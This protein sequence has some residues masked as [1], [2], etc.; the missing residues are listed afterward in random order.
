MPPE[1]SIVTLLVVPLAAGLAAVFLRRRPRA[2]DA[3]LTSTAALSLA[4]SLSLL[5]ATGNGEVHAL[6]AGAWPGGPGIVLVA[7]TLAAL[8]LSVC[9][10]VAL[11]TSVYGWRG[12]P[13]RYRLGRAH[14]FT[15]FMLFGVNGAFLAR[16]SDLLDA[17]R[18]CAGKSCRG[19]DGAAPPVP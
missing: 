4:A 1:F 10:F 12:L 2:A 18:D 6:H 5:A 9:N 11:C 16:L 7:D 15:A 3:V 17:L 13:A 8:M 19:L 14:A